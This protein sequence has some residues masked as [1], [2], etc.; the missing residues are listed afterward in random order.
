MF[1]ALEAT[2]GK[3]LWEFYV[4]GSVGAGQISYQVNGTQYVTVTGGNVVVTFALM[5]R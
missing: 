3:R 2:T 1:Y 5:G 4:G